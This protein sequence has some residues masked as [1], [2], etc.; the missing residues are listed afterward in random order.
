MRLLGRKQKYSVTAQLA[1]LP[2]VSLHCFPL[3]SKSGGGGTEGPDGCLPMQW[4]AL[5]K[6][7][8]EFGKLPCYSNNKQDWSL[9]RGKISPYP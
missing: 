3:H 2:S 9:F 1:A 8:T 4:D 7:N 5:Q 6:R